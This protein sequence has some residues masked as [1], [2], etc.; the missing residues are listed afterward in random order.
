[1][2]RA[3]LTR[4]LLLTCATAP[5]ASAQFTIPFDQTLATP[6][7][8][9]LTKVDECF[10]RADGGF[11][12]V[13]VDHV[14]Q[15][16]Y[17]ATDVN[18]LVR[19]DAQGQVV[20]SLP[21]SA[22]G[23]EEP[24]RLAV[25][26][27]DNAYV[28]VGGTHSLGGYPSRVESY[29]S[30]ASLRWSTTIPNG[31]IALQRGIGVT[32][33]GTT[34]VVS[35]NAGT[36]RFTTLDASG[37]IVQDVTPLPSATNVSVSIRPD[38]SVA[39]STSNSM[40]LVRPDGTLAWN[41]PH[42]L[43]MVYG[44]ASGP[45]GEVAAFGLGGSN[46]GV[47]QVLDASG[48]LLFTH[49]MPGPLRQNWW[50]G[51]F[52]PWGGLAVVGEQGDGNWSNGQA[53]VARYDASGSLRWSHAHGVSGTRDVFRHARVDRSGNLIAVGDTSTGTGQQLVVTSWNHDGDLSWEHY[54]P[55]TDSEQPLALVESASGDVVVAGKRERHVF[56]PN[57]P[58][59][60]V[61]Y[62][63]PL[64]GFV[65]GLTPDFRS[66]CLG[67]GLDVACPC[68]NESTPGDR[69]GCANS[70]GRGARLSGSGSPSLS[71]D[72]LLLALE[73][74]TPTSAGVYV[75]GSVAIA[76]VAFGDGLRCVGGAL[77]RLYVRT[78]Q[79]GTSSAPS[80]GD[81]SVSAQSAAKG[82]VIPAGSSRVYQVIYRDV[83]PT[84][85]PSPQ[86]SL[87]NSSSAVVVSW[88]R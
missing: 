26:A 84:F 2:F 76:P 73:G 56:N 21:V 58:P 5:A 24:V 39:G 81:P 78:A 6:Q 79:A 3:S 85:C 43:F 75:Q 38:G 4:L 9:S 32:S 27:A 69:E 19:L 71:S 82:D 41:V 62:W 52:D 48:A 34:V 70:S 86:G 37:A 17:Y 13:L 7:G 74:S 64:G 80:P 46:N 11:Y 57:P 45:A 33:S 55:T 20:G 22:P 65:L 35:W 23:D 8:S 60:G 1:M 72:T 16:T 51:A 10:A 44:T 87:Q 30:S 25:D 28:A 18:V 36:L 66:I 68:G 59:F 88:S 40:Y 29:D 77:L 61:Y 14:F 31:G 83:S 54:E 67:D 47:V 53:L 12:A 63:E 15:G 42:P 49:T 50:A